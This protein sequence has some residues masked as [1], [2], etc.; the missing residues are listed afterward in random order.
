MPRV[1]LPLG[2]EISNQAEIIFDTNAPIV[3]NTWSNKLDGA[4]PQSEVLPLAEEQA[5]PGFLVDWTG[6][7]SESGLMDFTIYVSEDGNPFMPWIRNTTAT[8]VD[9]NGRRG[10]TYAFYSVARDS[11]GNRE[12]AP[13]VPDAITSIPIYLSIECPPDST[14]PAFSTIPLA[15]LVGFRIT[16]TSEIDDLSY[17]YRVVGD[18]PWTVV[19]NGDSLSLAGTTP[20]IPPGESFVPPEAA[21]EIGE[22]REYTEQLVTYHVA[23]EGIEGANDSCTTI[24]AFI[25]PVPVFVTAFNADARDHGIELVWDV[26]TDDD[27]KGFR[28]HRNEG[29]STMSA[30]V[31]TDNI[32]SPDTRRF[33]DNDVR[34]GQSYDY[35]LSIVLA[36]GVEMKSRVVTAKTKA[37]E[38]ALH[39]N[40]PNPFNPSTTIAFTLPEKVHTKLTIYNIAGKLVKTL[41]NR[42]LDA[43][44]HETV[45]DGTDGRGS[46]VSSGVYFYR[47]KA[48]DKMLTRKMVLL[49]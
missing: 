42:P 19:D 15:T 47:L 3:T 18:G 31:I 39:Q 1:G 29:G 17:S 43:G 2:T 12:D 32:L 13:D 7:D 45:W 21:L 8:S 35:T 49:K 22:V 44:L 9:F 23:P 28:I 33:V 20:P 37:F 41:T 14:V 6:A 5:S 16:N 36:D 27:I 48:G 46:S 10:S 40:H 26:V 24:I 4:K 25:P 30:I 38:L 11:V 34:P